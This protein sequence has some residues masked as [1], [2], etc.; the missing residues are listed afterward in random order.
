MTYVDV[1]FQPPPKYKPR[2]SVNDFDT[3]QRSNKI[4]NII[5][6]RFVLLQNFVNFCEGEELFKTWHKSK[7]G[8][9]PLLV[10][11]SVYSAYLSLLF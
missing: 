11:A 10:E 2:L 8:G 9:P 1:I 4:F 7:T 5:T 6:H 3:C